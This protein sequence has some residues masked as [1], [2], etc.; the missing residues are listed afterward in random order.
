MDCR[1]GLGLWLLAL[2]A[3]GCGGGQG[4][5]SGRV[6]FRGE[7]LPSGRVTFVCEGGDKPVLT[8]DVRDG[9]Y[10]IPGAP[11]GPAKVAVA[12]YPVRTTPV[13]NMP[14]DVLPPGGGPAAPAGKYV[15]LPARYGDPEQSG[16]S[17]TVRKGHQTHDIDLEP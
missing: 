14:P 11:V 1:R 4:T 17:Y 2:T 9:A 16:L 15:A 6:R 13:P 8:A 10:T 12:T 3:V 5:V 7:P